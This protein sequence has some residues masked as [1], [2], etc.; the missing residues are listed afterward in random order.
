MATIIDKI[1]NS[2]DNSTNTDKKIQD[3]SLANFNS[4]PF[5]TLADFA[6]EVGTSTTSVIRFC[7][8]RGYQGFSDF[9]K[10]VQEEVIHQISLPE[11]MAK[12]LD[13][14]KQAKI[15]DTTIENDIDSINRTIKSLPEETVVTTLSHLK[16]AERIYIIGLRE[17][18]SLAHYLYSRLSTILSKAHLLNGFGGL[19]PEEINAIEQNDLCVVFLFPRYT[20]ATID[21]L[22]VIQSRNIPV[23]L[24]TSHNYAQLKEY[25]TVILPCY[26]MGT[27]FK[28]T[29]AAPIALINYLTNRFAQEEDEKSQENLDSI[30]QLLQTGQYLG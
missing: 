29:Y 28:N 22:R 14:I 13:K 5:Y 18:F 6:S 2:A 24:V 7:K 20:K 21:I 10:E 23:V 16:S 4:I 11:K 19:Y 17:S 15:L 8:A 27:V 25:A 26:V 30:E 12:S 9:Q 1:R 3:F